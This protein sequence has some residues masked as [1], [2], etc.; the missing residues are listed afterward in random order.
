MLTVTTMGA[1]AV[2]GGVRGVGWA[3]TLTLYPLLAIIVFLL[4][5][6]TL[7]A[8]NFL[9]LDLVLGWASLCWFIA[10]GIVAIE[11]VTAGSEVGLWTWDQV[12]LPVL[13]IFSFSGQGR[14]KDRVLYS[15]DYI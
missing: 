5:P 7:G 13:G 15:R 4:L 3:S 8:G 12:S 1:G 2:E 6:F 10:H 11:L 14:G 9:T